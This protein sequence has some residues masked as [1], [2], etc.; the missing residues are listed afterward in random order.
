[1][2]DSY[3]SLIVAEVYQDIHH[4]FVSRESNIKNIK[5]IYS[6]D[7]AFKQCKGFL[8]SLNAELIPVESTAK[9]AKL[10]STE[11]NTAAICSHIAGKL[12]RV[13]IMF[14]N[15]ED[16]TQNRTRFLIISD[17][18]NSSSGYDKT[19]IIAKIN[20]EKRHGAL[21]RF[22]KDFDNLGI[23]LTRIES[24]PSK[25]SKFSYDF[26]I[27]FDGHIDDKNVSEL[28]RIHGKDIK[29]LGSYI[30]I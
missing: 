15:I 21:F 24:R 23:N 17:F 18:K 10:A 16:S 8:D 25:D 9:A 11:D 20:D 7:I 26:F 4:A 14:E 6:K 13:P 27:D 30:K 5:K 12:Y 19:S 3:N 29:W 28:F 1:M 22:L 2:L